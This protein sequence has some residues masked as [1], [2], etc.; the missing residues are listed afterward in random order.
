ME[1]E[2]LYDKFISKNWS[3][4]FSNHAKLDKTCLLECYIHEPRNHKNLLHS[5]K[6]MSYMIPYCGLRIHCSDENKELLHETF[7]KDNNNNIF[8]DSTLPTS[9]TLFEYNSQMVNPDFW[10]SFQSEKVLIFQT[11]SAVLQN[12]ILKFIHYDYLGARW[13]YNPTNCDDIHI[14]NGGFSLRNPRICYNITRKHGIE[15]GQP[16]DVYFAKHFHYCEDANVPEINIADEFSAEVVPVINSFG[17]HKT[18]GYN[19]KEY[20][21]KLFD[22]RTDCFKQPDILDVGIVCDNKIMIDNDYLKRW[23]QL[24]MGPRG[25]YIPKGAV[26]PFRLDESFAGSKKFLYIRYY[27]HEEKKE[28]QSVLMIIK[29]RN[30]QMDYLIN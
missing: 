19:P 26:V 14:G 5:I 6:N 30:I 16:E 20:M 7:K 15:M 4:K 21:K 25:I 13:P 10:K 2:Y 3:S 18:Y 27:S 11:D 1:N 17:M 23:V 29:N 9:R 8:I 24:G 22:V 12:S 28:N